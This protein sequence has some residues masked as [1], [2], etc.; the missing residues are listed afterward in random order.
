[1]RYLSLSHNRLPSLPLTNL[2]YHPIP[3]PPKLETLHLA[4]NQL[5]DWE[6]IDLINERLNSLK[7]LWLGGNPLIA[8]GVPVPNAQV[9]LTEEER[10]GCET[11]RI[12][13]VRARVIARLRGLV[14][15]DGS[16][17]SAGERRAAEQDYVLSRP[18]AFVGSNRSNG[19]GSVLGQARWD[20]LVARES[21][22]SSY[23]LAQLR[24]S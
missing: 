6:T 13:D 9:G 4:N 24:R 17:V 22:H 23:L 11:R 3:L 15:L 18:P 8:A 12:R 1:M 2:S 14:V 21:L 7:V 10:D 16:E 5:A 19:Q 20:E